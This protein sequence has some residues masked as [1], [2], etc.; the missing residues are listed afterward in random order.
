MCKVLLTHQRIIFDYNCIK[1]INDR[2][3]ITID[4]RGLEVFI[5]TEFVT[6]W[7]KEALPQHH[8]VSTARVLNLI[9]RE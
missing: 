9:I 2:F 8:L 6:K 5:N 3:I 1:R 4:P 7:Y